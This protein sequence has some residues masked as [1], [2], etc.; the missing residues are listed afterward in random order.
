MRA[1]LSWL[2][3]NRETAIGTLPIAA[4]AL[5]CPRAIAAL[6][7]DPVLLSLAATALMTVG[8]GVSAGERRITAGGA[9]IG[10]RGTN[11]AFVPLAEELFR[12]GMADRG[13]NARAWPRAGDEI[14]SLLVSAR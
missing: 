13:R 14:G 2:L 7:V 11:R 1:R 9:E 3:D 6:S 12:I 10:E 8:D 5:L 4:S